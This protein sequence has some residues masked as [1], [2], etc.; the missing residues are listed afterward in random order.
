M[1]LNGAAI[2]RRQRLTAAFLGFYERWNDAEVRVSAGDVGDVR[3][4]NGTCHR[5][6]ARRVLDVHP[7]RG[8]SGEEGGRA[9]TLGSY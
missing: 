9:A 4:T 1:R 6:R 5:G 3:F 2:Q 7:L 8:I